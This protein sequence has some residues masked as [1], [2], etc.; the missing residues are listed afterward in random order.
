MTRF[1]RRGAAFAAVLGHLISSAV[2]ADLAVKSPVVPFFSW[3]G[4]YVGAHAG[5]IWADPELVA[6]S[7]ANLTRSAVTTPAGGVSPGG[8]DPAQAVAVTSVSPPGSLNDTSGHRFNGGVQLGYN[9][10]S[11]YWIYGAETDVSAGRRR[12]GTNSTVT[13]TL[14]CGV[15]DANGTCRPPI[16]NVAQT[17]TTSSFAEAEVDWYG[18]LRARLGV[19]R[20]R[21]LAY[22]TG[23]LAYGT[24]KVTNTGTFNGLTGTN[25]AA[26][27][28]SLGLTSV[29]S[30]SKTKVGWAASVGGA[31][32]WSDTVSVFVEWTRISLGNL[33]VLTGTTTQLV[34]T[35]GGAVSGTAISDVKVQFDTINVGLNIKI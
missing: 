16:A 1:I 31:Y 3:A 13:G 5:Y 29:A 32:A 30:D 20:D 23:G 11:G 26:G 22:A 34:P 6:T 12:I 27:A 4:F 24:V 18:T 35:A 33:S 15:V 17:M 28:N 19:A 25:E 8:T 9:I 7:K 10:Q 2:A 21:W 14:P